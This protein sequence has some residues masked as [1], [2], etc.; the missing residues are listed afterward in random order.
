MPRESLRERERF[1]LILHIQMKTLPITCEEIVVNRNFLVFIKLDCV[2]MSLNTDFRY[3]EFPS[4][5]IKFKAES[6][7]TRKKIR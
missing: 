7:V 4:P 2:N 3:F 1:Y 6:D 5:A